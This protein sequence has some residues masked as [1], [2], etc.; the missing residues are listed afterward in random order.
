MNF[1]FVTVKIS[2][3]ALIFWLLLRDV[4]FSSILN[5]IYI[6]DVSFIFLGVLL[7]FLLNLSTAARWQIIL[8]NFCQDYSLS[9]LFRFTLIG[10]FFNQVLPTGMGG[11][12]FR[13]W[14]VRNSGTSLDV[15]VSSVLFDRFSGLLGLSVVAMV[16][17]PYLFFIIDNNEVLNLLIVCV[18][19]LSSISVVCVQVYRLRDAF[20]KFVCLR[21]IFNMTVRF[22]KVLVAVKSFFLKMS[23]LFRKYPDGFLVVSLS[24]FNQLCLG[25]VVFLI[26]QAIGA[27]L[28]FLSVLCA[29]PFVML[30]STVPLSFAGWGLREGAMVVVFTAFG[31]SK[32]TALVISIVFGVSLFLSSLVGAGLWLIRAQA[33]GPLKSHF[34]GAD[35][36]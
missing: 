19:L 20:T 25:V 21:K 23:V 28:S 1:F 36:V 31:V 24:I 12:I 15:S 26:S 13:I 3:T 11:D 14:Y 29:V 34:P 7:L 10:A 2:I 16:G 9:K 6:F 18:V 32:E 30:V 5:K 17:S 33:T 27:G 35:R 22:D 4:S 8:R